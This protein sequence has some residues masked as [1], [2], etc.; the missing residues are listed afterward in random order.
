MKTIPSPNIPQGVSLIDTHCHLDMEDYTKDF[1]TVLQNAQNN[2]VHHII[3][4][5]IDVES[6]TRA[7]QLAT[8]NNNISATI[9]I[10]PH[11]VV[12]IKKDTYDVLKKL[13]SQNQEVIVGYGEIGL[14]YAKE[15]SPTQLQ[16]EH[17]SI[18]LTLAKELELPLII[19]CRDAHN[20]ILKHLKQAAPF[21][22]GGV[23]HC[24]SGDMCFAEAVLKLGFHISIPGIVTFK[25]AT[26][27]HE[28][29]QKI[30]L[31]RMLLET[32]GP[33]LAPS[34]YRGRRN[35]PAY[36]VYTAEKIA[37][38]RQT[39]LEHIA[40]QTTKNAL[41]LFNLHKDNNNDL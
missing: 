31:D 16:N 24:F 17:F 34:P 39:T 28:V 6:S 12:N 37:L 20:D 5:G 36:L 29:A 40:L 7:V 25:N 2:G 3:T 30:P 33:F 23:I 4:I 41:A 1:L 32:D 14:D 21:P 27:L 15:N 18:Q 9:G 11:D 8:A 26:S 22:K 10:H 19:H 13:Y 35:E 38:L